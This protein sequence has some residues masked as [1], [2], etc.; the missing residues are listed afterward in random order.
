VNK[1]YNTPRSFEAALSARAKNLARQQGLESGVLLRGFYFQR[2]TARAFRHDPAGWLLKGGQALLVR[3]PAEARLSRD[4][5]LASAA[6]TVEEALDALSRAARLDLHDFFTF[7]PTRQDRHGDEIGGAKQSFDVVIGAHRVGVINVDVV[8]GRLPTAAPEAARLTP[9]IAMTWPDDWPEIR[10]YPLA[11]HIAD[12]IC[13]MYEWH[14]GTPSS[15]YRDLADLLLISQRERLDSTAIQAALNSEIDRRLQLNVDLRIPGTFT[16]P[17]PSW[18]T[19]YP[20]Q[21]NEVTGLR[22]CRT[23]EEA[24][25]AAER[26][27]T[28]LLTFTATPHTWD[29]TTVTWSPVKQGVLHRR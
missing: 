11:D 10:L 15:R 22:G 3:Y 6:G 29:P 7:T 23:L 28:P 1:S 8:A 18:Q 14:S 27:L 12:K 21:A 5:D 17:G 13:A 16:V 19:G 20:A 4:I 25:R 9:A 24:T 2:L 26:F